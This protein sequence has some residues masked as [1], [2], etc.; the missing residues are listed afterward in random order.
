MWGRRGNGVTVLHVHRVATRVYSQ[1]EDGVRWCFLCRKRAPF[2]LTVHVPTDPM[3]YY[4]PH[5]SIECERGHNNGDLF[6]GRI[7]EWSE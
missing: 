3:S 7:R 1:R 2:T 6:P 4:G 5:A